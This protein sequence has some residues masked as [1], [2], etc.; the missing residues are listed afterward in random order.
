MRLGREPLKLE[1]EI[2]G[3]QRYSEKRSC[4]GSYRSRSEMLLQA[5]LLP[6]LLKPGFEDDM[7][8]LHN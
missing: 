1:A 3:T 7:P 4:Y 6:A 8:A 2:R 5:G